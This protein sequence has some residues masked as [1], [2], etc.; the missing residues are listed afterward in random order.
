MPEALRRGRKTLPPSPK[1]KRGKG[2]EVIGVYW[3]SAR[4]RRRPPIAGKTA[5]VCAEEAEQSPAFHDGDM[6][7]SRAT[8]KS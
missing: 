8:I 3:R 1:A 7:V 5:L 2:T 4:E 6:P